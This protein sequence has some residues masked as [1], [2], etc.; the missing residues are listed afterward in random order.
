MSDANIRYKNGILNF[1]PKIVR[2]YSEHLIFRLTCYQLTLSTIEEY[3]QIIVF[4]KKVLFQNIF[5]NSLTLTPY[6]RNFSMK[7]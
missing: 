4:N 3:F 7:I 5:M 1:T 6:K 2:L